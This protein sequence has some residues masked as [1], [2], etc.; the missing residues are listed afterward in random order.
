MTLLRA[1][2]TSPRGIGAALLAGLVRP[3]GGVATRKQQAGGPLSSPLT[4][5][6]YRR[7]L[8]SFFKYRFIVFYVEV[9]LG[10]IL[11]DLYLGI[12]S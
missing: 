5:A 11:L 8:L 7:P 2:P 3:A 4:E 10:N 9:V 12:L 6:A 1:A